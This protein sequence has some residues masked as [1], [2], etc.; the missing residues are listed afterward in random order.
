MRE[1]ARVLK[2]GG[3]LVLTVPYSYEC[4]RDF[5]VSDDP[6]TN[7]YRGTRLFYQRHYD[8]AA[9]DKRLVEPSGFGSGRSSSSGSRGG[10]AAT[11]SSR[12]RVSRSLRSCR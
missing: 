5:W 11:R 7:V 9:L 1:L 4:Y 10:A 2:P 3:R 12:T 6:Y 8:D